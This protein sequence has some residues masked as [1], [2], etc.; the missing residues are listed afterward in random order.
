M[1][2]RS[3]KVSCNEKNRYNKILSQQNLVIASNCKN[4][5]LMVFATK[6]IVAITIVMYCNEIFVAMIDIVIAMVLCFL[7]VHDHHVAT[8]SPL[9]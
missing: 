4:S 9:N 1:L 3:K 6:F 2:T 7:Y 5:I 8:S